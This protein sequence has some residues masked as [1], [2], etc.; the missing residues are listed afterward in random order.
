MPS[1]APV[2]RRLRIAGRLV[3]AGLLIQVISLL[4]THPTAF[5]LFLFAGVL[6]V[7]VGILVYLTAIAGL[8]VADEER[9]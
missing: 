6:P 4:W 2:Y 1:E 7:A 5:F 3:V 8:A 9:A